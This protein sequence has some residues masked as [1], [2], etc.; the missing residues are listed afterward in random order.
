M[1]VWLDKFEVILFFCPE[2]DI[3]G[4]GAT[5]PLEIYMIKVR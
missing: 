5:N 2:T 1:V 4:A 3:L